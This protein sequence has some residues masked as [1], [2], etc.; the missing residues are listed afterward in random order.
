MSSHFSH[1]YR[2]QDVKVGLP[3]LHSQQTKIHRA[4]KYG[5]STWC[6]FHVT[7]GTVWRVTADVLPVVPD[8][9]L[10]LDELLLPSPLLL[11]NRPAQHELLIINS[12]V[13]RNI[14]LGKSAMLERPCWV[15][16]SPVS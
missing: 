2:K 7:I 8:S 11:R 12:T 3:S 6:H 15:S 4:T 9:V 16:F 14:S 5:V 10:L 13:I 1:H